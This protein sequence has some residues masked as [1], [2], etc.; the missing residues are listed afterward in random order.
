M[1][2]LYRKVFPC[3]ELSNFINCYYEFNDYG[4]FKGQG[5][6]ILNN[7]FTEMIIQLASPTIFNNKSRKIENS[8]KTSLSG[9]YIDKIV[10]TTTGHTHIISVNFKPG[11]MYAI[12]GIPQLY[13]ESDNI[14]LADIEFIESEN[15]WDELMNLNSTNKRIEC[16][17]K[18]LIK[19][20]RKKA[21][22]I[23]EMN[24]AANLIRVRNGNILIRELAK[25][26]RMSIRTFNRR[27]RTQVGITPKQYSEVIRLNCICNDLI[28]S[29]SSDLL[30]LATKY[31]YYDSSHLINS[32]KKFLFIT[33]K[34]LI[35]Y[36]LPNGDYTEKITIIDQ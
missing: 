27:F 33:P 36:K 16:I 11:G 15:L 25:E 14:N 10:T 29:N 13:F 4:M 3:K 2:L 32:F 22:P 1:D 31:G 35:D 20:Y 5:V 12:F 21:Q 34:E 8:Y 18:Y 23:V 17:E 19:Q 6:R 7:G 26:L 24:Y 30:Y 28:H 9:Q